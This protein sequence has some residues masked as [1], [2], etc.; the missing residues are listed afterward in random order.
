MNCEF[1]WDTD[2]VGFD[3]PNL[4]DIMFDGPHQAQVEI[5]TWAF[6]R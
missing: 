2:L 3:P 6:C 1:S 5:A 4:S